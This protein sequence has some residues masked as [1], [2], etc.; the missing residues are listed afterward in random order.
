[1]HRTTEI[2]LQMPE[3]PVGFFL[4]ADSW[5]MKNATRPGEALEADRQSKQHVKTL[6]VAR[7]WGL[8]K[9]GYYNSMKENQRIWKR[10]QTIFERHV[11]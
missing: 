9:L 8:R 6:V 3:S 10:T 7:G 1:M 2:F 4:H 5:A 11:Q